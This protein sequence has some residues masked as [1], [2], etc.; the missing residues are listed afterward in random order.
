MLGLAE[1][2]RGDDR[3]VGEGVGDDHE[4]AGARRQIDGRTA[5]QFR[6]LPLGLGDIGVAGT[7]DLVG[8]RHAR[9]EGERRNR[10]GAA[11]ERDRLEPAGRAGRQHH[12]MHAPILRRRRHRRALG[13]A[14]GV[15]RQRQHDRVENRGA[16]PPGM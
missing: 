6:R 15:R 5:R 14:R 2:I 12:R 3:R 4:L 1:Q 7:E 13:H 9:A 11:H 8:A 10:L 16:V